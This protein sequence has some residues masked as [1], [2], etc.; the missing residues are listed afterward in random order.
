MSKKRRKRNH[1]KQIIKCLF[2]CVFL[3]FSYLFLIT[4]K[5][6]T[7]EGNIQ[8]ISDTSITVCSE[9]HHT[10][11]FVVDNPDDYIIHSKVSVTYHFKNKIKS[12]EVLGILD[13]KEEKIQEIMSQMSIEEKVGQLF[14]VRCPE[15]AIEEIKRYKP[16]GYILFSSD[17]KND[18]FK[19]VKGKIQSYQNTSKVPMLIAVDEEGGQVTRISQFEQYHHDKFQ[20]PQELYEDGGFDLIVNDTKDKDDFLK[21]LGINVNFGPVAD[22][23]TSVDDFIYERSFGQNAD[24]TSKYVSTVVQVMKE[25]HM[26]RVLKHFPGYGNNEDTHVGMV[27]DNRAYDNFLKSDFIPFES[28]IKEGADMV[29]VSHNIVTCMDASKPASLSEYVHRILREELNFKGV[30]ITDDLYMKGITDY[31]DNVSAAVSAIKAGNDLLCCTDYIT[32][33]PAVYE[34]IKN[35]E[36]SIE[37]IDESLYRILS[38]KIDLGIIPIN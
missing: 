10:Y 1:F 29:L 26:G 27:Q 33:I 5:T 6:K 32:Q 19:S 36:I 25:D 23:S 30:I 9:D 14:I 13:L 20:S 7:I 35:N 38:M 37:R 18:T 8:E 4:S 2:L 28:G 11:T 24:L 22:V 21:S 34:A 31:T 17:F 16:G 15:E 12:V 3:G